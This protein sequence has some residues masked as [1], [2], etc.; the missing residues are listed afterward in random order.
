[1]TDHHHRHTGIDHPAE[2][3]QLDLIEP[4]AIQIEDRKPVVRIGSR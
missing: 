2:R 3:D 1:M 4:G